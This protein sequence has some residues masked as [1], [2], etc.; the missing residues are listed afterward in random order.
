MVLK[1]K[2]RFNRTVKQLYAVPNFKRQIISYKT[3][4]NIVKFSGSKIE[5]HTTITDI[6]KPI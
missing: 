1:K 3:F 2:E 4:K 5:G 6:K